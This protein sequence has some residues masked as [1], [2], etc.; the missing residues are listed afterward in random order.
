MRYVAG[1]GLALVLPFLA[2]GTPRAGRPVILVAAPWA[3]PVVVVAQAGG[4]VI[5][6]TA[7]P[8]IIVAISERDDFAARLG[9]AG[10]WLTLDASTITGCAE[11]AG[12][13]K[14]WI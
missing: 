9:L 4:L 8:W 3:D 2:T 1:M 12:S 7:I 11:A 6:G 10:A 13:F 14:S 5:R